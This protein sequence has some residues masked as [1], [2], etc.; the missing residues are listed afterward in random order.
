MLSSEVINDLDR[1][2]TMND[3]DPAVITDLNDSVVDG[4]IGP[5]KLSSEVSNALKLPVVLAQPS[6]VVKVGG[7]SAYLSVGATGGD[8]SYQWK[9][10][11]LDVVGASNKNLNNFRSQRFPFEGNYSVVVSN[12]FGSVTSSV[13]QIDVNGSLTDGLVGWWKF[14]E[15]DGSIAYDS[16]GNNRDGNFSSGGTW[17]NGKLVGQLI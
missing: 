4:S 1:K 14:D 2:I 3:L 6:S 16:S 17:V 12:A 7:T 5:S 15:I 9:K 11:G 10:N 13:A 8:N